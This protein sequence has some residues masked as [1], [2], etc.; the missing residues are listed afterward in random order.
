[1]SNTAQR[2][3]KYELQKVVGQGSFGEVWKCYDHQ[4]HCEIAL[5][6][7]HADLQ[8]DPNFLKRFVQ[9]GQ[10]LTH[11]RHRNIVPAREVNVTRS[12]DTQATTAYVAMDYI[13]GSTLADYI[14][15]T[16]RVGH[17]PEV[18]DIVYI[19]TRVGKAIDYAYQQGCVHGNIKPSNI[20]LNRQDG[21]GLPIG[22]PMLIDFGLATISGKM[23]NPGIASAFYISPEQAKGMPPD[24]RS[25]IYSLGVILY[26]ICTGVQ[27][28]RSESPIAVMMQ[29]LNT[30][31]TPPSLINPNVPAELS[32]IILRA[33]S[34]DPATRYSSAA[35]LV[36]ALTEVCST[37]IYLNNAPTSEVPEPLV[38]TG[39]VQTI[40]GVSQPLSSITISQSLPAMATSQKLPAAPPNLPAAPKITQVI[41][42]VTLFETE[43]K[44]PARSP[45]STALIPVPL[46]TP[47]VPSPHKPRRQLSNTYLLIAT[48]L[49]LV[50]ITSVLATVAFIRSQPVP[51]AVT[52]RVYF[53]SD[54]S[55]PNDILHIDMKALPNP[56]AA[57]GYYAWIVGQSN[58]APV[59]I[60]NLPI[61]AGAVQFVYAGTSQ[62]QDLLASA[63]R[64]LITEE[65][66]NLT[67]TQ[68]SSHALYYVNLPQTPLP[69]DPQRLSLLDHLRHLLSNVPGASPQDS[70]IDGGL[71]DLLFRNTSKTWLWAGNSSDYWNGNPSDQHTLQFIHSQL[72]HISDVMEG[73]NIDS[74]DAQI[75]RIG[76]LIQ[77]SGSS[78]LD[79]MLA[80]LQAIAKAPEA[81][82]A[83]TALASQ[84]AQSLTQMSKIMQQVDQDAGQLNSMDPQHLASQQAH[85]LLQQMSNLANILYNGQ[86]DP[87]TNQLLQ[88]GASQVHADIQQLASFSLQVFSGQ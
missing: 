66:T 74:H 60:G 28:F 53:E 7:L 40:L 6:V 73:L 30:L 17:F 76:L 33:M 47:F 4:R 14:R 64:I 61:H 9:E 41:P 44:E 63:S 83:Q 68:P 20:L 45:T 86:F 13:Q 78:V 62:H 77:H 10:V 35:Q 25:D 54:A 81:S 36:A 27:P 56:A 19:F 12:V 49:L 2:I 8:S 80:H 32:A 46:Q 52:G 48:V 16:A 50:I 88:K 3:G 21:Q 5:K 55:G 24:T 51:P 59:L 31:P 72:A 11:L 18:D 57:M 34:K 65:N 79:S 85:V 71:S 29:H 58:A 26:E 67:P 69:N 39:P 82:P 38:A 22:E 43:I 15:S 37:R 70:R 75:A 84:I 23:D 42:A 87:V 1:M